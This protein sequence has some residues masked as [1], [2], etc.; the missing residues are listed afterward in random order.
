[1]YYTIYYITYIYIYY[2]QET[3]VFMCCAIKIKQKIQR[4]FDG[5]SYSFNA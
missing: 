3:S 5:F 4:L 1:M 2:E